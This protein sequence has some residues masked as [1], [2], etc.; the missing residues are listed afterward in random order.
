MHDPDKCHIEVSTERISRGVYGISGN[1]IL[2][3]DIIEN[4]DTMVCNHDYRV[5]QTTAFTNYFRL[6]P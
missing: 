2:N 4:D 6:K 5:R 1:I 3:A